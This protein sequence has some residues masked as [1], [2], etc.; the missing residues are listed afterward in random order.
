MPHTAL[1][2]SVR[3][4]ATAITA[5]FLAGCGGGSDSR[6]T[7]LR[8]AVIGLDGATWDILDPWIEEGILP[9][10]ARLRAEGC[11]GDLESVLPPLSAPAWTSA[12]TGVNPAKHGI[13]DFELVDRRKFLPVP[14]T[15][16][17]R[18]AKA[19]WEYMTESGRRSVVISVPVTSPPDSVDG[20]M[21][22]G[23]P[24]LD[25]SGYTWP[26]E[27][28]S[29]LL[30]WRLDRYGEYLPPGGEDAFLVNLNATREAR[31]RI[32][33]DLFQNEDWELFWLVFMGT[34]KVQHFFWKF[35]DP[36]G[37]EVDPELRERYGSA[38]R[39]FWI[40]TDEIV[41]TFL[42]AMDDRTVLFVI[43][44]HGFGPVTR[45]LQVLRW[46]WGEGYCDPNPVRSR[47]LYFTHLGG[48]MTVNDKKRF[49]M[50]VVEPEARNALLHE[51]RD[52]LLALEDPENGAKVVRAAYK[53]EEI[54]NGPLM[55]DA[56]DL[57]FLPERGYFFGRGSPYEEGEGIFREPSYTFSAYHE[58]RGIFLAQGPFVKR[59]GVAGGMKLIDLVPTVLR[60]LGEPIPEEMDGR[61]MEGPFEP[62]IDERA[63][64]RVTGR[65]ITRD[66]PAD[67]V[68]EAREN[69]EALPYLR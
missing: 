5:V 34:D 62:G 28:E 46:L 32:A 18:R 15:S 58:P 7:G 61:P 4:I 42:D 64:L 8:V 36:E 68:A 48:R 1:R 30:G 45:E 60:L 57:I 65:S 54:Y 25:Q 51:I 35:M 16:L 53:K 31:A 52:K 2:F 44:D 19:A 10:L 40:R 26:P 21:I 41:G 69:L 47:V 67:A 27:L 33:L 9:N 24:H 50:G 29:E 55:D 37:R 66:I 20:I 3:I 22:S 11:R 56:P 13:F 38:I 12:I 39:D 63:P 14:A 43:S 49:P 17:D 6:P 23:F 59:G